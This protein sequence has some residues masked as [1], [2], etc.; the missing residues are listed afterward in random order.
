MLF[1]CAQTRLR[2]PAST[3]VYLQEVLLVLKV[4]PEPDWMALASLSFGHV[5]RPQFRLPRLLQPCCLAVL[6]SWILLHIGAALC[7]LVLCVARALLLLLELS[8]ALSCCSG[9]S[10]LSVPPLFGLTIPPKSKAGA[11]CTA[12]HR[13]LAWISSGSLITANF[14]SAKAETTDSGPL[15]S[16]RHRLKRFLFVPTRC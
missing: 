15:G 9:S 16:R 14:Q 4:A 7:L 10:S 1:C 6:W 8:S 5:P 3:Q 12:F 2:P 11:P 13:R